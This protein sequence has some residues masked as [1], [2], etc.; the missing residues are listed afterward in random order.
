MFGWLGDRIPPRYLLRTGVTASHD[1]IWRRRCP[2]VRIIDI[3]G[4]HETLY[5]AENAAALRAVVASSSPKRR[6]RSA[7]PTSMN[8]QPSSRSIAGET[9]PVNAPCCSQCPSCAP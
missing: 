8:V 1:G 2:D 3:P 4:N 5:E 6:R 7:W 9:H